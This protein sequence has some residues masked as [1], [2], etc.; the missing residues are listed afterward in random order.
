M[1]CPDKI[2]DGIFDKKNIE[3]AM[4]MDYQII[5]FRQEY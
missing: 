2:D 3:R 1:M 4:A 5:N